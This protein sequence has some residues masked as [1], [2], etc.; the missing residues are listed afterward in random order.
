MP[1]LMGASAFIMA[2]ILGIPFYQVALGALI[3]ALIFYGAVFAMVHFTA[4]AEGLM[5]ADT[6]S[7]P[8]ISHML[9]K[10]GLLLLPLI[11]LIYFLVIVKISVIK[12]AVYSVLVTILIGIFV[13]K[14]RL[15]EFISAFEEAAKT[16]LV[17]ISSTATAGI[18]VG[19]INLTGL[20]LK[21][22]N[23][24]LSVAGNSL[25]LVLIMIMLASLL[26]GMGLPTTPAYLI[27]AVLAA[28]TLISLGIEPLAA[29]M[30]VFYFGC[31][32]MITPP[33]ALAVYA[34][35][36]IAH[37]DFW[38]TTINAFLL[39]ISS[40]IVPYMFVYNPALLG[41]GDGLEIFIAGITGILGASLLGA[42]IAGWLLNRANPLERIIL[43]I[44]GFFLISPDNLTN[45]VGII[46]FI[47]VILLQKR[48]KT[49]L[50]ADILD[51]HHQI[52]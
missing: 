50:H 49:T 13:T 34:A 28:P 35:T 31:M 7:L 23:L 37:S 8:K 21:F 47:L 32:S 29:H 44:S 52:P 45:I 18:V 20:G 6:S 33:V 43:I 1:P 22:S 46:G 2:E 17:V 38:K 9:R 16:S 4:K 42:G 3:P 40:F 48:K 11:V 41:I 14:T 27:L 5:G 12:A 24:M 36:S 25:F 26:L 10:N 51:N 39:G 19:I 15:K 30:F